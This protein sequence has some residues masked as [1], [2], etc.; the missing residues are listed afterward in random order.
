VRIVTPAA[1]L[2]RVPVVRE[3]LTALERALADTPAALLAG[4]YVAVLR[5]D[6]AA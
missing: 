4:F 2:L 6:P 3:A 5:K 1:R